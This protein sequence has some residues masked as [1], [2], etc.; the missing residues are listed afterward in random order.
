MEPKGIRFWLSEAF[1]VW[2]E[3]HNDSCYGNIWVSRIS[4]F[5]L[6]YQCQFLTKW[7]NWQTSCSV[8]VMLLQNMLVLACWTK[9]VMFIVLV[10]FSWRS[11]QGGTQWITAVLKGRLVP[12]YYHQRSMILQ[13]RCKRS[14]DLVFGLHFN[15]A[16]EPGWLAENYGFQP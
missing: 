8:V 9:E 16:G 13:G 2:E 14:L 10:F 4:N 5:E 3:L 6:F 15:L 12:N 11:L 7:T 1:G